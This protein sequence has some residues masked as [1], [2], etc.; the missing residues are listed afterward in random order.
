MMKPS[1]SKPW[2]KYY[3]PESLKAPMPQRTAYAY[4][5]EAN[6]AHLDG[7]ALQYYGTRITFRELF[8]RVDKTANAFAALGVKQG[9]IV[10]FVSVAVPECVM[11]I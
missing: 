6:A 10:S 4:L 7:A 11:A 8:D 9:D 1:Q 3:D 2:L 5:R